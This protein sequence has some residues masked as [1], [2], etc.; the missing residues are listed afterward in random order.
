[1]APKKRM[2]EFASDA[3]EA[4][5]LYEHRNELDD[6]MDPMTEQMVTE[7]QAD[8]AKLKRSKSISL[9][10][11]ASDLTRAK[12][13]AEQ[14]GMGYQTYLKSLI[15]DG[16]D[17]DEQQ[18]L[19]DVAVLLAGDIDRLKGAVSKSPSFDTDLFQH[20]QRLASLVD[21]LGIG[22]EHRRPA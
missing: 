7:A 15:R 1:M 11:P 18:H 2:P 16:L 21:K 17:R 13:L 3:D 9:R 12:A 4:K 8:L 6:Y 19:R 14:N 10:L 20:L 5:W 22:K